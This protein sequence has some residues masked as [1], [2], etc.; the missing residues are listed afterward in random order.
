MDPVLLSRIQFAVTIG[1]HFIFASLNVGLAWVIVWMMTKYKNTNSKLYRSMSRFWIK[2]FTATFAVGVATGITMEFQFGTNWAGYSKFVGDIFG[3]PLAIEAIIAFFL[4]STF[5]AVLLL[6]WKRTS[7]KLLWFSSLMVAIGSTLSAFWILVANSWQQTPAGFQIVDGRA[8]L[9]SFY[10]AVMNPSTIP[11]FLHT[12]DGCIIQAAFFVMG[13]SAWFIL[14]KKNLGFARESLKIG[15]YIAFISSLLQIPIG[16]YHGVQV[17]H[18]QPAKL[19]A[20]E[21]L[22]ETQA[23]APALVFA[24]PDEKLEK[25]HYEIKIPGLLS[26]FVHNRFDKEVQ[27]LKDFPKDEWPPLLLTFIPFHIMVM[28]GLYFI[29]LSFYGMA[30]LFRWNILRSRKFLIMA[31]LSIPLPFICN[32]LGWITAEVGRQPWIVY[33]LLKTA[34]AVSKSITTA[35]VWMSLIGFTLVYG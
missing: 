28:L 13:I 10:Q 19:A 1:F 6:G 25:N 31:M 7:I 35:Q 14:K 26:L 9:V 23:Y 12:V 32:Q 29:G 16:H 17:A 15:L 2:I 3:A 18:T 4:E 27:G 8:E 33:G 20:I 30:L 34:D 22:F 24:I 21:G 11:R 5:L